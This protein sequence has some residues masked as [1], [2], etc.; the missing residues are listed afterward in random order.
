MVWLSSQ[1]VASC[2]SLVQLEDGLVGD[3]QE[4]A[5]LAAIDWTVTKG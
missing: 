4:K 1:V 3:P 5:T 2:H